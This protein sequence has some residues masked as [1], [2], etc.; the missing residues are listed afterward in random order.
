MPI[1]LPVRVDPEEMLNSVFLFAINWLNSDCFGLLRGLL[2]GFALGTILTGKSKLNSNMTDF[3]HC[4]D[5]VC[6]VSDRFDQNQC[7]AAPSQRSVR[8]DSKID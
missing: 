3:G 7:C 4:L 2:R 6:P 8:S 1:L 5:R